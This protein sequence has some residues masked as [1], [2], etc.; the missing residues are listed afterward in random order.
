MSSS[1]ALTILPAHRTLAVNSGTS[2]I[3]ALVDHSIFLRSDCGGR[4]TCG[5]YLVQLIQSDGKK[6]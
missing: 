1:H 6:K 4:G 2:L 5:K 3:E